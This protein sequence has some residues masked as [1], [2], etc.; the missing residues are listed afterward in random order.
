MKN[1]SM[2]LTFVGASALTVFSMTAPAQAKSGRIP[3]ILKVPE[4]NVLLLRAH[5]RGVQKY[6]RPVSATSKAVPH[7]ILVA[8]DGGDLVAIHFG[9]PTW[10][11]L[12]GS[13][14]VGDGPN[15]KHFT[16]PDRMTLTGCCSLPNRRRAT[17]SLVRSPSS[18]GSLRMADNLL[19]R[20]ATRR[21]I[22]PRYLLSILHSTCSTS[23]QLH[24]INLIVVNKGLKRRRNCGGYIFPASGAC[25]VLS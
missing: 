16:P 2:I 19:R 4:G 22:R 5:G 8:G 14:V 13:S 1:L 17:A 20:A 24:S 21:T 10:E 3:D 9:G 7:A 23:L 11:A 6:A 25:K 18:N 12:D 15:A